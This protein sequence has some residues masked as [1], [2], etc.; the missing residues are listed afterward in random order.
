M[1]CPAHSA[2]G[3]SPLPHL[4]SLSAQPVRNTG[5]ASGVPRASQAT[6]CDPHCLCPHLCQYPPASV[7]RSNLDPGCLSTNAF[8]PLASLVSEIRPG[9]SVKPALSSATVG[10]RRH[11]GRSQCPCSALHSLCAVPGALAPLSPHTTQ[12]PPWLFQERPSLPLVPLPSR[13]AVPGLV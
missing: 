12:S 3:A 9:M 7:V 8:R 11:R 4:C 10:T 1:P 5:P 13:C 2:R 6:P